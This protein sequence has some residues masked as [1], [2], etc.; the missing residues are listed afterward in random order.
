MLLL[1]TDTDA[2]L[3]RI[4]RRIQEWA[5][6]RPALVKFVRRESDGNEVGHWCFRR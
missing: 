3:F 1:R 2:R 6:G 5:V 4:A